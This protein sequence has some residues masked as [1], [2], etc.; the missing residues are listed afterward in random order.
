MNGAMVDGEL[1]KTEHEIG[2]KQ[3]ADMATFSGKWDEGMDRGF[4]TR[5]N[6]M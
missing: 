1:R 5:L 3:E 4:E 2:R 6:P